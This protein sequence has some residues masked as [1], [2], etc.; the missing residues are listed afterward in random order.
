MIEVKVDPG[1]CGLKST[2]TAESA[3]M[4]TSTVTIKSECP[5]VM[6]LADKVKTVDAMKDIF[7][8]FGTSSVFTEAA[9]VLT[10]AACPVPTAILK[11][12]EASC[13]L[14]LPAD[15]VLEIKKID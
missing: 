10:H 13:S 4:M 8:P 15:V 9:G 1:V 11:A 7:A 12:V 14:A 3:D 2:I 6:Q 5:A